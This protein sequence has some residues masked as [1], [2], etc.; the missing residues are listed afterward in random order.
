MSD[1]WAGLL[2]GLVEGGE[3]GYAFKE[4]IRSNRRRARL[5]DELLTLRQLESRRQEAE[6]SRAA[7]RAE[8][9]ATT[10]A[11]QQQEYRRVQ[12]LRQEVGRYLQA[13]TGFRTPGQ[14][15]GGKPPTRLNAP[16]ST[17]ATMA[18]R[19]G[20]LLGR[21][22]GVDPSDEEALLYGSGMVQPPT[23]R[24]PRDI[25]PLS[26]EGIKRREALAATEARLRAKY[27]TPAAR[28]QLTLPEATKIV[29][30][31]MTIVGPDGKF[32]GYRVPAR[33]RL[34]LAQRLHEGSLKPEDIQVGEDE[35]PPEDTGEH[36]YGGS[37]ARGHQQAR[38]FR[39]EA[40]AAPADTSAA[41]AAVGAP[42]QAPQDTTTA[43]APGGQVE[44][45]AALLRLPK[46]QTVRTEQI[47]AMLLREGYDPGDVD[48]ALRQ[49]GR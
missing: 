18:Q 12:G 17:E 5:E 3:R 33:E 41:P 1:A 48:T 36:F 34:A 13:P 35:R 44:Q 7:T 28:T 30:D 29:D 9:E 4:N 26:P 2:E 8:Q 39:P 40:Y 37:P 21:N 16:L 46:Y 43:A 20:E 45:L 42:V 23:Y 49:A 38:G 31:L 15:L 32:A 6:A 24:A 22:A 11:E 14:Y 19:A 25:D 47:R 10:F 27:P